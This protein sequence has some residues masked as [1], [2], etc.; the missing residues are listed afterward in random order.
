MGVLIKVSGITWVTLLEANVRY[1]MV[2]LNGIYTSFGFIIMQICLI[3][4]FLKKKEKKIQLQKQLQVNR[5]RRYN[6]P[7][8]KSTLEAKK[9]AAKLNYLKKLNKIKAER[10]KRVDLKLTR[11][12]KEAKKTHPY[13]LNIKKG[14][15]KSRKKKK[16]S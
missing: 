11:D 10:Q 14:K 13:F 3:I 4:L 16:K 5:T 9:K 7:N 2:K 1:L 8:N 12:F 15:F 6:I